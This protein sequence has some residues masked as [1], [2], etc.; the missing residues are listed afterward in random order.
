MILFINGVHS[1]V[2]ATLSSFTDYQNRGEMAFARLIQESQDI[3]N[4]PRLKMAHSHSETARLRCADRA[5]LVRTIRPSR[6][7][8]SSLQVN[9]AEQSEKMRTAYSSR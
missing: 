5:K 7:T 1:T 8:P 6:T 4:A 3:G 2:L 9:F